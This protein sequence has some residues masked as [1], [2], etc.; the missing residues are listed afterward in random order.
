MPH[1]FTS[2]QR[3]AMCRRLAG[4]FRTQ[5]NAIIIGDEAGALERLLREVTL[6][7]RPL[8][9]MSARLHPKLVRV[10]MEELLDKQRITITDGTARM[11]SK[12]IEQQA[13]VS[14]KLRERLAQR[15]YTGAKPSY[16]NGGKR[17]LMRT[18]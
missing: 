10:A 13:G 3:Q 15:P 2:D 1:R 9:G 8:E 4:V 17:K 16:Q 18:T 12:F 6:L 14:R 7:A 11:S 5:N